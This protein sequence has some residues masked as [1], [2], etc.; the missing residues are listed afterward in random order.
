MFDPKKMTFSAFERYVRIVET[1]RNSNAF[2]SADDR[3]RV[4]CDLLDGGDSP[5]IE[6]IEA[7]CK[8]EADTHLEYNIAL[9]ARNR[10]DGF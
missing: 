8:S 6:S 3:M 1:V 9:A 2:L 5:S 4:I 7:V 10:D